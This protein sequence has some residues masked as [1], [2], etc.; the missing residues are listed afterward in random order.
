MTTLQTGPRPAETATVPIGQAD[1]LPALLPLFG[2]LASWAACLRTIDPGALS[3]LG[4]A[5]VLPAAA[6]LPSLLL[7]VG[8]FF[9]LCRQPGRVWLPGLYLVALAVVLH[10][11]PAIDYGTLRYPWAWKH[12]GI[13][14]YIQRHGAVDRA[15]PI[16][17]AY[18]NWPGFFAAAAFIADLAG[19]RDLA[20]P[21]RW[22]PLVLNLLYLA[23]LPLLYRAFTDDHRTILGAAWVFLAGNWVG[24]DYFSPQG[25]CF[26]FY[27]L[28]IGLCLRFLARDPAPAVAESGRLSQALAALAQWSA[29]SL[30]GSSALPSGAMRAIVTATALLLIV[31]MTVSHQLTPLVAI[32]ALGALVAL[33]IMTPGLFLFAGVVVAFWILY[34][35]APFVAVVLPVE[36]RD[37]GVS[38]GQLS[39][40][41]ADLAVLSSGQVLVSLVCRLLTVGIALAAVVGGL[42]RRAAGYRDGVAAALTIAPLPLI[43]VTSYG[44]EIMFRVYLFALPFL[45]FF[46]AALV[47]PS[48][49]R[50]NSVAALLAAALLGFILAVAFV[51]ANNGKD[52]QYAFASEDV[53][54][55]QW[56]YDNAP[57]GTLIVEGASLYPSL[58]RN[59]EHVTPVAIAD[60]PAESRAELL[61]NPASVLARW[62]DN[63]DYSAAFIILTRNQE[64]YVNAMGIMP[65]GGFEKIKQALL[66][67]PRFRLVHAS[68]GTMIF[69]LNPAVRGMG[70]W[71][72]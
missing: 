6:W 7:S 52:R 42:R 37:I 1:L 15:T 5:S 33:Q 39:G 45:A 19:I 16:L 18:H 64:A 14:D 71:I 9:V 47:F 29:R 36:I 25:V 40:N 34:V 69:A 70:E 55:V 57:Q 41:L 21:V 11:T 60:E 13:I 46:A 72:E 61:A 8:F 28:L 3:D 62:L 2:A 43:A 17:T 68:G 20:S 24:Q 31:A 26:F 30:P 12:L 56:L 44:G 66:S 48:P 23:A 50:G 67:S 63:D 27:L 65:G 35:A 51:F 32:S 59:V 10:A 53:A 58:F 38:A 22:A 49:Q 4:L 54:A